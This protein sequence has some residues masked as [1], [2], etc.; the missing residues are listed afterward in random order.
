MTAPEPLAPPADGHGADP[1]DVVVIGFG[2]A[3]ADCTQ[4]IE[5]GPRC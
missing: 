4:R 3:G 2:V 1:V 5:P